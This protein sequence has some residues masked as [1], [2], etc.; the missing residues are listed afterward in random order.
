MDFIRKN[1]SRLS[2]ALLYF[3]GG[4]MAIV[5]WVNY[6]AEASSLLDAVHWIY[7]FEY[8]AVMIA[9][10]VF[11]FGTVAITIAK[12]LQNSKK[13]VSVIYMLM[14]TISTLILLVFV[15]LASFQ[16]V[17]LFLPVGLSAISTFFTIWVPFIV[18]G[19]HPLIK[20]V[21]R[22]VEAVNVPA[23][24]PVAQATP[25]VEAPAEEKAPAKKTSKAKAAK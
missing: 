9:T 25:A 21:T 23:A 11:F 5:A 8:I 18:F 15:V 19:L 12:S 22:F 3:I 20:G 24:A 16:E 10:L 6:F 14:G 13:A 17:D 4:V 1:W 7:R 2:L